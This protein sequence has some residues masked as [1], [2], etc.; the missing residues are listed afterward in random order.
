EIIDKIILLIYDFSAYAMGQSVARHGKNPCPDLIDRGDAFGRDARPIMRLTEDEMAKA[1]LEQVTELLEQIK[2]GRLTGERLQALLTESTRSPTERLINSFV[3]RART[4]IGEM[5]TSYL[6]AELAGIY[7]QM[8][9][10]QLAEKIA[11]QLSGLTKEIAYACIIESLCQKGDL[12]QARALFGIS[13]D[14]IYADSKMQAFAAIATASKNKN[15]LDACKEFYRLHDST[16]YLPYLIK[17][18]VARGGHSFC[19]TEIE[20]IPEKTLLRDNLTL[21]Y[22]RELIKEKL[23]H[24]AKRY[25]DS[26]FSATLRIEAAI[27][28][29]AVTNNL[30]DFRAIRFDIAKHIRVELHDICAKIYALLAQASRDQADLTTSMQELTQVPLAL[31]G[32]S[33]CH[34][35]TACVWMGNIEQARK[36]A[37]QIGDQGWRARAH[38]GI[39]KALLEQPRNQETA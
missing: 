31:Q 28:I 12:E 7:A 20:K 29:A 35:A 14:W 5:D 6:M 26:I 3:K 38:L 2:H 15:D 32:E 18:C 11:E 13:C 23:I 10:T 22:V 9:N 24:T 39:A 16:S 37:G 4:I 17:A 19:Q 25:A 36:L 8:G 27:A 33:A 34:I 21:I 1:T 30:A